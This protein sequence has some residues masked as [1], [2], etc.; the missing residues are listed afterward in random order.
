MS[1]SMPAH[2]HTHSQHPFFLHRV[3]L[4]YIGLIVVFCGAS[5]RPGGCSFVLV[6][7]RIFFVCSEIVFIFLVAVG[8]LVCVEYMVEYIESINIKRETKK[9]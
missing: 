2:S 9:N 7:L 6:C 5:K 8:T 1:H 3:R 4:Q